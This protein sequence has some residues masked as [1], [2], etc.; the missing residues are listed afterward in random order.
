MEKDILV[1][2]NVITFPRKKVKSCGRPL[3]V[4]IDDEYA[5][6]KLTAL[7]MGAVRDIL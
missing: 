5:V 2:G 3:H 1:S 4:D 7:N 6:K